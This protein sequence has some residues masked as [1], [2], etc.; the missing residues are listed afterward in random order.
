MS[1]R[2]DRKRSPEEIT[3]QA[4]ATTKKT[5]VNVM[6]N[7]VQQAE[8]MVEDVD[9]ERLREAVNSFYR[10]WS[11]NLTQI[12]SISIDE[13][14]TARASSATSSFPDDHHITT[15]PLQDPTPNNGNYYYGGQQ[16]VP[17]DQPY[18]TSG[19]PPQYYHVGGEA[20]TSVLGKRGRDD[21][22]PQG[23]AESDDDDG[24]SV[25]TTHFSFFPLC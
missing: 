25:V 19:V 22:I 13:V 16:H 4:L 20:S 3:A 12:T 9:D 8:R 6:L 15:L 24:V 5:Y 10:S 21:D 2:G 23:D 1:Q 11:S 18:M 7:V 14:Q 17:I